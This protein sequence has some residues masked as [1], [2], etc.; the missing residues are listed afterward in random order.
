MSKNKNNSKYEPP[1]KIDGELEEVLKA[2]FKGVPDKLKD[3]KENKKKGK[4]K[5]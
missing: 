2:S 3:E 5:K 4:K 1:L